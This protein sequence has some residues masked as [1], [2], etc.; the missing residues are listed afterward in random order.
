MTNFT[1]F[2][3]L[4][5]LYLHRKIQQ[6]HMDRLSA[7]FLPI[8]WN[9]PFY[10]ED[11]HVDLVVE[12]L[13]VPMKKW[14]QS[15]WTMWLILLYS[16]FFKKKIANPNNYES[17]GFFQFVFI[18]KHNNNW[19]G[20]FSTSSDRMKGNRWTETRKIPIYDPVHL[21]NKD[22]WSENFPSNNPHQINL[23]NKFFFR[24]TKKIIYFSQSFCCCCTSLIIWNYVIVIIIITI[25]RMNG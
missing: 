2:V 6:R 24:N 20:F 11:D 18:Y 8:H 12:M 23:I 1:L 4:F 17:R 15:L 10:N 16:F 13:I 3:C 5:I 21:G 25:Y 22:M 9:I 7:S 19:P 14:P